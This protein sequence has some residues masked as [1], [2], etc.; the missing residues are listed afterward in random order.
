[1]EGI[2]GGGYPGRRVAYP[3]A[4]NTVPGERPPAW[5]QSKVPSVIKNGSLDYAAFCFQL[6]PAKL[7]TGGKHDLSPIVSANE[8]L[9][10]GSVSFVLF[11]LLDFINFQQKHFLCSARTGIL[12][13]SNKN[14]LLCSARVGCLFSHYWREVEKS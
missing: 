14:R 7:L 6:P 10:L 13:I 8:Y 5:L 11:S 12:S 2:P 9:P 1:M 3:A 4:V